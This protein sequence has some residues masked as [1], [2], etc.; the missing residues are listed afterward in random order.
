MDKQNHPFGLAVC[1][2]EEQADFEFVFEALVKNSNE[3]FEYS[4]TPTILLADAACQNTNAFV[5]V[6]GRCEKRIV[7]WVS[8]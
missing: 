8:K 2:N 4:Y 5:K 1:I 7:C 3:A 6:F